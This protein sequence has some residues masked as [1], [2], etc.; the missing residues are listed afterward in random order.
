MP[1]SGPDGHASHH[2]TGHDSSGDAAKSDFHFASVFALVSQFA[3]TL[4]ASDT[5][6]FTDLDTALTE[7]RKTSKPGGVGPD[8]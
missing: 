4:S 5:N 8:D 1:V 3:T 6:A 7:V 2:A